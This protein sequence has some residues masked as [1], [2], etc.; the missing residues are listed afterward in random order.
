M[1][2]R[3]RELELALGSGQKIVET[4]ESETVILQRRSVRAKQALQSGLLVSKANIE[5]LRPCPV[6]ALP[7]CEMS[8]II[9]KR[10]LHDIPLGECIRWSDL[11]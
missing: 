1:M 9:G 3:V 7:P 8:N 4:N 2:E 5:V 10:L 11:K 6:D